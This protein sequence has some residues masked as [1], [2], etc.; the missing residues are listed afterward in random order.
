MGVGVTISLP[1]SGNPKEFIPVVLGFFEN[2]L[3]EI[4]EGAIP[5]DKIGLN[6]LPS[7][8]GIGRMSPPF[9]GTLGVSL[10]VLVE[11]PCLFLVAKFRTGDSEDR[12][13]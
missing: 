12:L 4:V 11:E 9:D 2:I 5:V 13:N 10:G 3:E 6:G 1:S 7:L 8:D